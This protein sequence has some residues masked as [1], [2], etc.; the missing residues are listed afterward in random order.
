MANDYAYIGQELKYALTMEAEGFSIDNND[1][2]IDFV[3]GKKT[4][5]K[6]PEDIIMDEGGQYYVTIDTTDFK[7]GDL[8]AIV[9]AFVP[10]KDFPDGFRTEIVKTK[11]ATLRK[12]K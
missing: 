10:D 7:P 3:C 4:I 6:K 11:L 8:Y 1:Y 12:L 2:R 5:S 9:Y